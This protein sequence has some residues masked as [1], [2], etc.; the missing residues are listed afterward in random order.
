[1]NNAMIR[2]QDKRIRELEAM[3]AAERQRCLNEVEEEASMW[4]SGQSGWAACQAIAARISF[5][6]EAKPN[7]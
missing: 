4:E 1:M 5:E 7:D 3:L 2:T 6:I